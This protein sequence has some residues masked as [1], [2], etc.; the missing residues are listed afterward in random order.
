MHNVG[1]R[2]IV[3]LRPNEQQGDNEPPASQ[4]S[5]E[6]DPAPA[7]DQGTGTTSTER[8]RT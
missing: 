8:R 4:A 6:A 2:C 3:D 7:N 5:P 1:F